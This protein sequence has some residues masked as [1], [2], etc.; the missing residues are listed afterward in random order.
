MKEL[1][2][3]ALSM[4]LIYVLVG[5]FSY[6]STKDRSLEENLVRPNS[7]N[8]WLGIFGLVFFGGISFYFCTQDQNGWIFFLMSSPLS[9]ILVVGYFN[10]RFFYNEKN[11]TYRN[12]WGKKITIPYSEI[13]DVEIGID[14]IIFSG[15]KKVKIAPEMVGRSDFFDTIKPHV[16]A[17]LEEKER[18]KRENPK[19]IPKVRK[20]KDSVYRPGEFVFVYS[21]L[22]IL[23]IAMAVI[24]IMGG[25]I[26][27]ALVVCAIIG[28]M[29]FLA[30]YAPRRAHSSKFWLAITKKFYQAY[31]LK[32]EQ[33][34]DMD[35]GK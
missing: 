25:Y 21:M 32:L 35:Y 10:C 6:V 34:D 23:T 27:G 1:L 20:F 7:A 24:L 8:L 2:I 30:F 13:T 29:V 18:N 4:I 28:M 31:S 33:K 14:V 9:L 19:Q 26:I 5:V 11:L 22:S 15:K 16:D 17:I 3:M 12:F